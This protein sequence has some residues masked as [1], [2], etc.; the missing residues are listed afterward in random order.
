MHLPHFFRMLFTKILLFF[1]ICFQ[2]I[3]LELPIG[4][5]LKVIELDPFA[6]NRIT[7]RI[8]RLYIDTA[9]L[10]PGVISVAAAFYEFPVALTYRELLHCHLVTSLS[11]SHFTVIQS[12]HCH[13][14]T[15]L[16]SSHF[17]VI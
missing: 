9:F 4:F 15:S 3:Q 13:P 12:L 5:Q 7:L 16:S 10:F 1:G 11:S 14:V 8:K 6:R 2:I 17:T